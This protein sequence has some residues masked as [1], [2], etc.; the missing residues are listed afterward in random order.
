MLKPEAK[1]D[2]ML[3]MPPTVI[4]KSDCENYV[5][6]KKRAIYLAIVA[7]K[8]DKQLCEEVSYFGDL[9]KPMLKIKPSGK[10][11][12]KVTILVHCAVYLT[13]DKFKKCLPDKC[14]VKPEWFFKDEIQGEE[15]SLKTNFLVVKSAQ[16]IRD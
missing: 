9:T 11:G 3:E 16:T 6:F 1:V 2:I 10:L 4:K 13:K 5:Y 14:N 8:L 12:S 15:G 7:A